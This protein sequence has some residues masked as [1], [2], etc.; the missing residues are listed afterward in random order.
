MND[1]HHIAPHDGECFV[2]RSALAVLSICQPTSQPHFA[3]IS[4]YCCHRRRPAEA[5]GCTAALAA[6][7]AHYGTCA[8]REHDRT[9]GKADVSQQALS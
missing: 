7:S 6:N 1:D 4:F 8:W 9:D 2:C 3:H 5:A